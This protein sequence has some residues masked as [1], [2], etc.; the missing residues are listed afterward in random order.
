VPARLYILGHRNPD[1]DAISATIGYA[2]LLRLQRHHDEIVDGR[3]GPLRPET[4]YLLERFGI[5]APDLVTNVFPRVGDVMTSPAMTARVGE[6]LYEVAEKLDRLGMRPLPVVDDEGRFKGIAEARDFARVFFRGM[7][8]VVTEW[9]TLHLDDIVRSVGG[10]VLVAAPERP[11]HDR[12]MIAAMSMDSILKRL[13]PDILLVVGDRTDVQVAA[14]EQGVGALIVTGDN[15]VADRVIEAARERRVNVIAV[16]HHTYR[17]VQLINM[18]VPIDQVMRVDQPFCSEEDLVDD[19]RSTLTSV[20][21]LPVLDADDR[22]VGVVTR[23]DLLSPVRRRVILIDHNERSQSVPGIET[24]EI[25]GIVDHHRVADLQTNLPPLMR[26]EPLGACSTLVAR[27]YAEASVPVPPE[28]AGLLL[29]GIVADTL[30][31]RSPTV[32]PTDRQIASELSSVSGVDPTELGE[33][34]L[35]IASDIGGRSAEELVGFDAKDF[36]VNELRFSVS[37]VETTNAA[38]LAGRRAELVEALDQRRAHGYWSA[39]LVVVDVFHGRTVVLISGHPEDVARAF[40]AR[41]R[42][43]VAVD[44]PGVYSRK[45]QIIPR[46]AEIRTT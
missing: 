25:V 38:A 40:D 36:Q 21:A 26:V 43:G 46:L 10:T 13:E 45:K 11:L 41:L 33:A 34:I 35:D 17:T 27:L 4:T 5:P 32:T 37:V 22:V 6:T 9:A 1:T 44:L 14:I 31:F 29:G 8:Q 16:R 39:L 7:D 19:V 15:P 24:A 18:S 30:L 23:S 3:L 12:V 42:D 2:T 20:R 28:I